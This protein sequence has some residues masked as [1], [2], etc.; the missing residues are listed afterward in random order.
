MLSFPWNNVHFVGVG[1]VGMSGL[2]LILLE[3]GVS[4]SGSDQDYTKG[5]RR[6]E[7]YGGTVYSGHSAAQVAPDTDVLVYTSAV[8]EENPELLEAEQR[9]ISMYRRGEFLA[10]MAQ[11]FGTVVG[12]AGS[13]GKTTTTAF[14]AHIL[15]RVGWQPGYLIGGEV[16]AWPAPAAAGRGDVFVTEVDESDGTQALMHCTYGVVLNVEDDHCWRLGGEEDLKKCFHNFA[17]NAQELV[18][19]QEDSTMRELFSD[20]ANAVFVSEGEY[21]SKVEI[22]VPG[23]HNRRNAGTALAIA[24][25]MG[26]PLDA[27]RAALKDFPGVSRRM[28]VH[29][30]D[31]GGHVRL[32]EDYAHHPTEL[33]AALETIREEFPGHEMT[34]VFQPH[35][36]ERVRRYAAGFA[37]VLQEVERVVVTDPFAAWMTASEPVDVRKILPEKPKG[38]AFYWNKTYE[39]LAKKLVGEVEMQ[40]S[41]AVIIVVGAGDIE[42]I[43]PL[44]RAEMVQMRLA[45]TEKEIKCR[46]P[47][48]T[49][50]QDRTWAKLTTLG[51]GKARPLRVCPSNHREL[52]DTLQLLGSLEIPPYVLGH[53]ANTIG[54]DTALAQAVVQ[55]QG[56]EFDTLKIEGTKIVAGANVELHRLLTEAADAGILP[57][58][59]VSLAGI[60]GSVGGA[61]RMNAGTQGTW[62]GHFVMG[63]EGVRKDGDFWKADGRDVAWGYRWSSIPEDVVIATVRL[64]FGGN[65]TRAEKTDLETRV[66]ARWKRQPKKASAGC[67][68]LNAGES[69][70]GKL[71]DKA[72]C[73]GRNIGGCRIAD[74]HANFFVCEKNAK[75][76]DVLDLMIYARHT[77]LRHTGV[78]L[79]PEVQFADPR[80]EE[81]FRSASRSYHI[82]VF[83]GGVSSEREVSL[84]SGEAVTRALREAGHAAEQIDVTETSLPHFN[85]DTDVVF[86]AL[87]GPFG[88]DGGMQ[89]LLENAHI[90]YVGSDARASALIMDKV[91]TKCSLAEEGITTPAFAT[92]R[93]VV[94]AARVDV[95]APL[96]VKPACE[97]STMGLTRLEEVTENSWTQA[98]EKALSMDHEAIVE[99]AVDG[100]E[101]TVGVLAGEALP[102]LEIVP[103]HG[104]IFDYDAKYVHKRGHTQYLCPPEHISE[105]VQEEARRMAEKVFVVLGARDMLRVDF[106]VDPNGVPWVLEA[107][108]IPGFT[109]SSLLPM[110]ARVHGMGFPELCANLVNRAY[111]RG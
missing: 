100:T 75:E 87:H 21:S 18:V 38:E 86:P 111:L 30:E 82:A 59:A 97:G 54:A 101:M 78:Y 71:I 48:V 44:L 77:V 3:S 28:T 105:A 79:K 6:V 1:G 94:P 72:G 73:R 47:G 46:I 27:C 20:H 67:M 19:A 74:E 81:Y 80:T 36:F 37:E 31:P 69:S 103:P 8:D 51:V 98:L 90:P 49:V 70:A 43:I 93:E 102:A 60:P 29:Y 5:C 92:V 26:A 99:K 10:R 57:D 88:E 50:Q 65:E 83:C 13:H 42:K 39:E 107:N 56:E 2:A 4:V 53:G 62:I 91:R 58:T 61:L 41:P 35:R 32:V 109:A 89:Q 84:V 104:G 15:K 68:F 40:E 14:L 24:E 52:A 85:A 108:S 33:K 17:S 45:R 34:V 66:R 11:C 9:N 64:D 22:P 76:A 55:P 106:I 95:D 16:P 96:V 12:V 7:R 63:L 23:E 110:A 25:A